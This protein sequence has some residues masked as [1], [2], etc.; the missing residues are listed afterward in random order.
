M[1]YCV[2]EHQGFC[3]AL[4]SLNTL[5]TIRKEEGSSSTVAP[6]QKTEKSHQ[7]TNKYSPEESRQTRAGRKT[8]H[9]G[10]ATA[11][12]VF[13]PTF[14]LLL[15][16]TITKYTSC[17]TH[18]A[19]LKQVTVCDDTST[20]LWECRGDAAV[21]LYY[22]ART[23]RRRHTHTRSYLAPQTCRQCHENISPF[24]LFL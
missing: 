16:L 18:E 12:P 19:E 20:A 9:T 3:L 17:P 1:P 7:K 4:H 2:C 5:T 11:A 21:T 15:L 23:K 8:L 6:F 14:T 10:T 22:K 24:T 13:P